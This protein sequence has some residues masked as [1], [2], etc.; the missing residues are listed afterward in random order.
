MVW[1][2]PAGIKVYDEDGK[3]IMKIAILTLYAS[4]NYGNI[5][6]CLALQNILKENKYDVDVISFKYK[7]KNGLMRKFL[8]LL[9]IIGNI[10]NLYGFISD[11]IVFF[12]CHK[13]KPLSPEMLKGRRI[14]I[15]ANINFTEEVSEYSIGKLACQYDAIIVGSDMVWSGLGKKYL[16]YLFDWEPE[17][18]GLRISY[19]A[20]SQTVMVPFFNREKAKNL[21]LQFNALTVRDMTTY[22]MVYNTSGLKPQIVVDPVLLYDYTPFIGPAIQP[23]PYIFAYILGDKIKG[24]GGQ[25]TV[26]SQVK[27]QYG[28][29]KVVGVVIANVSLDAENFADEVIYDASPETW[30]NLLYHAAFVYTDSFHGCIFSLKYQKPF[31]GYYS[32]FCRA[33]RLKD[34]GERYGIDKYIV[35]SIKDMINKK[36]IEE[37]VDF[38]VINPIMNKYKEESMAF[39]LNSLESNRIALS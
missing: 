20:C 14:F 11:S 7:E 34:L 5:L 26:I 31:L 28:N 1:N 19:A 3:V 10:K 16:S 25:H 38:D 13:D 9:S 27:K 18:N 12:L 39:L 37:P 17:F 2:D 6:Q 35:S 4:S 21:F 23:E 36:S 8:L 33:T 15:K 32:Y 24:K 29:M 22:K 30:L